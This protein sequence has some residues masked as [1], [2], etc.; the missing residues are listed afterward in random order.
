MTNLENIAEM[1]AKVNALEVEVKQGIKNQMAPIM[2]KREEKFNA[3]KELCESYRREFDKLRL[4]EYLIEDWLGNYSIFIGITRGA[5]WFE[6][7]TL[8]LECRSYVDHTQN[9]DYISKRE[10]AMTVFDHIDIDAIDAELAEHLKQWVAIK[11]ERMKKAQAE[12]NRLTELY[13]EE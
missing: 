1:I 5:W 7:P 11:L 4:N 6:K 10:N 2:K 12:A 9:F 13:K 8:G 3:L